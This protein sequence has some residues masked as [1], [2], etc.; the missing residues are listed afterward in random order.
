ML[1][2]ETTKGLKQK[3]GRSLLHVKQKEC[4]ES[5]EM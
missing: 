5:Y 1:D 3:S 4:Y 2:K